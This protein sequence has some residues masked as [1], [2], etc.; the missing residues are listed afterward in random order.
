MVKFDSIAG[1][2]LHYDRQGHRDYG[3]RGVPATFEADR[4]FVRKLDQSFDHLWGLLGVAEVITT[5]GFYVDKPG[6]H[7]KGKAMDLDGIFW[8]DREFVAGKFTEQP[9]LYLAVESCLR[10]H[11]GTIL[12]YFYNKYHRDHFHI[13]DDGRGRFSYASASQT[14]YLQAVLN[15]IYGEE[16]GID[17]VF[18]PITREATLRAFD[19]LEIGDCTNVP[20]E[21]WSDFLLQTA[22]EAVKKLKKES[23]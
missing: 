16:L 7:R 10:L 11:N 6:W 20:G 9:V 17:G 19:A 5:A 22:Q 12:D 3:T 4:D 18:G 14:C 23:L 21:K 13:Q 15:F 2:P 8:P 1:V